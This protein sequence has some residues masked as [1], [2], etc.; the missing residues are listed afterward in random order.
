M[1]QYFDHNYRL[2]W[3]NLENHVWI[4]APEGDLDQA[5]VWLGFNQ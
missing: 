4:Y 5:L 1:F 2:G 3:A